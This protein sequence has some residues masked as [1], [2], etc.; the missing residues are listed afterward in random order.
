MR[1]CA[2]LSHSSDNMPH[3]SSSPRH[4]GKVPY[5]FHEDRPV[6]SVTLTIRSH[7]HVVGMG[8]YFSHPGSSARQKVSAAS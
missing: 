6:E 3:G 7:L 5:K 8:K 1:A 4:A 2:S